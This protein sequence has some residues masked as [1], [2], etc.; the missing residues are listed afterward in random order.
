MTLAIIDD[1]G[2]ILVIALFY[3]GEINRLYM[4]SAAGICAILALMNYFKFQFGFWNFVLGIVLWYCFF[5]SGIHS[6]VAGVVF[7]FLVPL[8]KLHYY[9]HKLRHFVNFVILPVFAMANTAFLFP[10][11]LVKDLNN[12]LSWGIIIGL[13][14]GKPLGITLFSWIVVKLKI[15]EKPTGAIWGQIIGI[16]IL[17]G[18]GF[19][20]SIF[21]ATL[22]FTNFATQDISKIAILMASLTSMIVGLI[23][24]YIA[25]RYNK[26]RLAAF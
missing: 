14:I 9:E 3:G 12:T 10:G 22:S 26:N 17:A 1:L 13:F 11:N 20:M 24:L 18:I 23:V 25:D 19:T 21:I 15:A 6:T 16:G 2:A 4:G 5:N 8:N 7:A